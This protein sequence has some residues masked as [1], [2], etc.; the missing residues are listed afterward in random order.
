MPQNLERVKILEKN[1]VPSLREFLYLSVIEIIVVPVSLITI[2]TAGLGPR[3]SGNVWPCTHSSTKKSFSNN[4]Y[5]RNLKFRVGRKGEY[6]GRGGGR[7]GRFL[8]FLLEHVPV[9]SFYI[10]FNYL[11][12]AWKLSNFISFKTNLL[13]PISM[14]FKVICLAVLNYSTLNFLNT[15]FQFA[16]STCKKLPFLNAVL[17]S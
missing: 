8:L 14:Y 1:R 10:F 9:I 15:S 17:I 13:V 5:D 11:M 16:I 12:F 7:N 4:E 3:M 2:T 6:C